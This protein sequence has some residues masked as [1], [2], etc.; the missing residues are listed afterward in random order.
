MILFFSVQ[1]TNEEAPTTIE[2]TCMEMREVYFHHLGA[3]RASDVCLAP[4]TDD[5]DEYILYDGQCIIAG[6]SKGTLHKHKL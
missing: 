3:P 1:K 6:I 4:C 5:L 2:V